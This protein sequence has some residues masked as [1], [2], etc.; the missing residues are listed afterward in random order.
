MQKKQYTPKQLAN[1][2]TSGNPADMLVLYDMYSAPLYNI[3][4]TMLYNADDAQ[5]TLCD[6][7]AAM[8]NDGHSYNPAVSAPFAWMLRKTVATAIAY[9]T[10]K[11]TAKTRLKKA[12]LGNSLKK[13]NRLQPAF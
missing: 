13:P 5:Q 11:V 2:L 1:M 7:F 3:L 9:S 6:A 10:D 4:V 12:F 8:R